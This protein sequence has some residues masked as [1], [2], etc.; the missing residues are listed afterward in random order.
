MNFTGLSEITSILDSDSFILSG[1][2]L[3]LKSKN[4]LPNDNFPLAILYPKTKEQVVE[5]VKWAR[6]WK[7]NIWPVSQ[8]KNWGYGSKQARSKNYVIVSL[9]K[10]NKII[11]INKELAYAIVEP[12]VSYRQLRQYLNDYHPDLW[13]DCT[14]GPPDGSVVGNAMD[15]GLGTTGYGDHFSTLCGLEVVLPTGNVIRT[16]GGPVN[17][18]TWNTHK[19]GIG[20]Y[21]EGLFTQGNFGIVTLAGIWLLPKPEKFISFTIDFYDK[22]DLP[23]I[24]DQLRRFA[25]NDI[26][27]SFTHIVNDIV[28]F[29]VLSQ[30][31]KN[32]WKIWSRIPEKEFTELKKNLNLPEWS[33]GG[34]IAGTRTQV[35]ETKRALKKAF[36]K[37][38]QITFL[39]D[40]KVECLQQVTRFIRNHDKSHLGKFVKWALSKIF[41]R[42]YVIIEAAPHVHSVLKGIPSD[43]FVRHAYLKGPSKPEISNLDRDNVGLIWFAPI[44]PF[45]G[46]HV[47]HV[48]DLCEP[49][50]KKYDF[51]FY[52]ALLLQNPRS[53]VVLQSIFFDKTNKEDCF[54]AEKLHQE[55]HQLLEKEGYLPYRTSLLGMPLLFEK[56]PDYKDFLESIQ[57]AIDPDNIMAPGKYGIN[58]QR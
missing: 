36:S 39:T 30:Y 55:L 41:K 51:D 9:E 50:Y 33:F 10:M 27:K 12:G 4:T 8:G 44:V 25:L 3:E 26:L 19:W 14:D 37:I 49:L 54:R 20:P 11:E 56:N 2:T 5:I 7:V 53:M 17:S 48:I 24:V 31:P 43:Y 28:L 21:L 18:Q 15:R 38:G 45:T 46:K 57:R 6:K 1:T 23:Y 52:L 40:K 13:C 29:S 16:G 42:P 22:K 47:Q 32:K 58:S 35:K 34:G